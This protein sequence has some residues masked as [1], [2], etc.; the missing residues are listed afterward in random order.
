MLVVTLSNPAQ[1]YP[2]I[3]YREQYFNQAEVKNPFYPDERIAN[4]GEKQG[5]IVLTL[6]PVFQSH[7][8]ENQVFL[9]GFDNTIMGSGHWN[10]SGHKLAGE[11]ISQKICATEY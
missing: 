10:K 4:L 9:H 1:V 5:F 8:D 11:I 6:A 7:A 2:D 3:N